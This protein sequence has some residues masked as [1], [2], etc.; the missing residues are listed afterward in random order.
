VLLGEQDAMMREKCELNPLR[1]I[2]LTTAILLS[3]AIVALQVLSAHATADFTISANPT[4]I[5]PIAGLP[6][7]TK[8]TAN[9][10]GGFSGTIKFT[11]APW[12][13]ITSYN[14]T[15]I[16]LSSGGSAITKLAIYCRP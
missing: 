3:L 5:N 11:A 16:T 14:P 6:V 8:I 9:S 2:R 7:Y 15:S 1:K 12:G 13:Y 4:R 10:T